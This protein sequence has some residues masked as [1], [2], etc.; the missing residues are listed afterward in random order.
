MN[1]STLERANQTFPGSS[2]IRR[3]EREDNSSR[4]NRVYGIQA[5]D[6]GNPLIRSVM[7]ACARSKGID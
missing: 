2:S 5:K 1:S 7:L 4:L 6:A 3:C